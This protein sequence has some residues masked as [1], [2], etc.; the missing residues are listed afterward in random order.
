M[1][2]VGIQISTILDNNSIL[3]S[4]IKMHFLYSKETP[5][6]RHQE[7]CTRIALHEIRKIWKQL[8]STKGRVVKYIV[9]IKYWK[10]HTNRKVKELDI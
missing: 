4:Q 9:E 7:T 6:N 10:I 3:T 1:L 2:L 8:K 5:T